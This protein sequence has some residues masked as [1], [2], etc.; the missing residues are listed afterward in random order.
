MSQDR[1]QTCSVCGVKILKMIGG[2][3]VIFATGAHSTRAILWARVCQ[4]TQKS[5][6]IN[7]NQNTTGQI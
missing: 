2:D 7:Q 1:N 6:C 4:Y 5:G 3:R